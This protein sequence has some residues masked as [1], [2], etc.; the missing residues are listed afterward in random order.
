MLEKHL[1]LPAV[2]DVT[3]LSRSTIY[4]MMSQG[5]FPRPIA[6][7]KRVVAWPESVIAKFLRERATA[8]QVAA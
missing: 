6:L 3:G 5:R 7:G 8:T 1:R 4:A 2:I